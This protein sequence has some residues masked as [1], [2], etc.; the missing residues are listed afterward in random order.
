MSIKRRVTYRSDNQYRYITNFLLDVTHRDRS[1]VVVIAVGRVS[2]QGWAINI[3]RY[4]RSP[5]R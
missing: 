5:V 2:Q 1:Y 3:G 4:G